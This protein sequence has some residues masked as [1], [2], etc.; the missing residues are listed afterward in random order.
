MYDT[1]LMLLYM[2]QQSNCTVSTILSLYSALPY[3]RFPSLVLCIIIRVIIFNNTVKTYP[4]VYLVV[5]CAPRGRRQN[6]CCVGVIKAAIRTDLFSSDWR[7]WIVFCSGLCQVSE[8]ESWYC[9]VTGPIHL[10]TAVMWYVTHHNYDC[11]SGLLSKGPLIR[12]SA[13]QRAADPKVRLH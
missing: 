11:D 9:G 1:M 10:I 3:G 6:N 4:A 12:K 2:L 5:C 8:L 7:Q 13:V